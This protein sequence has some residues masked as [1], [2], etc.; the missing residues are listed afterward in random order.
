MNNWYTPRQVPKTKCNCG[1]I[2]SEQLPCTMHLNAA[3]GVAAKTTQLS[4]LQEAYK[5]IE[6]EEK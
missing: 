6:S 1:T 5:L 3:Y 2:K 4:H